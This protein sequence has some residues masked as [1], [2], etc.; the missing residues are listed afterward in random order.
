[1]FSVSVIVP[2][3]NVELFIGTCV[4]SLFSQA[5]DSVQYIFVDDCSTDRSVDIIREV[6]DD[7]PE[8]KDACIFLHNHTN[9]GP[10]ASR[11]IGL[12]AATGKYIFF[13]DSDDSTDSHLLEKM[14]MKAESTHS[15][16]VMCDF[17]M[18]GAQDVDYVMPDMS[19]DRTE[20]LKRYI[21]FTW[22]VLWCMLYRR[23][24]FMET[25]IR[26][27]QSA[28]YC[29]D[30]NLNVKILSVAGT[31]VNQH[32]P[33]YLYNVRNQSSIMHHIDRDRMYDEQKMYMDSI[34]WI[35][36]KGL[37]DS[38]EQELCWRVLKSSQELVLDTSTYQEF[39]SLYPQSHRYIWSCPY[40]NLKLKIMMWCL[41]HHLSL[42]SRFM[43][44]A[45]GL[46]IR[47]GS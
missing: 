42:V 47:L 44:L 6:L 12:D 19:G 25:G 32:E 2:V 37:Y 20:A 26:F 39:L 23:S 41:S 13:C 43:L 3:F 45:R 28:R 1:M 24:L 17:R 30:F 16:I 35:K 15:D 34:S 5:L 46:R 8:R 22:T 9:L 4:R 10:S 18:T 27:N 7:F 38:L 29:E 31:V 33:L 21:R 40:L 36:D 14:F 11:N